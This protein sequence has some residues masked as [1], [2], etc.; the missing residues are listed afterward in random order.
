MNIPAE[1]LYSKDHEWVRVEGDIAYIG[2]TD[3]AQSS[4]GDIV[5]IE[6]PSL[7]ATVHTGATFG[8]VESVKA[9]SDLF[10]PVSGTVVKVNTA[11]EDN[12]GLLNSD[13][14]ANWIMAVNLEDK[15]A[16]AG[17]LDALA[18]KNTLK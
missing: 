17:L 13:S 2:I 10:C 7:G 12:P 8:V 1:L 11:L 5:F 14:Y 6:L 4:L 9:A 18:Y 15:S 3:Y 16:L